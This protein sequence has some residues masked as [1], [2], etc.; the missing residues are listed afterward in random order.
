MIM[1]RKRILVVDD[2]RV[3]LKS[4]TIKLNAR[5]YDVTTASDGGSAL[6]AVRTQPPD[7]ILLDISFPPDVGHGGGVS[8]DGFLIMTW[9]K[10]MEEATHIPIIIITG[11][12]PAKYEERARKIG[13]TAFF[14]K[15]IDHD[16]LF[17]VISK[18]L[19]ETPA[20][21]VIATAA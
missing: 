18:G 16:E 7:L 13:A 4:L 12:D 1:N 15:P 20:A 10:R 19:G 8:W 3:I 6:S 21:G 17:D 5:G 9:F 14:H 2:D 11:G